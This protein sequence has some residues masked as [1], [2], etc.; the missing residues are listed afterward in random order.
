MIH[1]VLITG[2]SGLLGR[3]LLLEF[4]NKSWE[5]CGLAF[6][7]AKDSLI[8]VDLNNIEKVMKVIEDFKPDIIVHSAAERSPDRVEKEREASQRL[9]VTCSKNL[10]E[11]AAI[12]NIAFIYISTDYVFDGSNPPY[13]ETDE[14]NPLNQYGFLKLEGEK[15]V[16]QSNPDACI[17]RIPVLYGDEEYIGE[18]AISCLIKNL[19]LQ[20]HVKI[21]NFEIR[22][23]SHVDDI[24]AVCHQLAERKLK[25]PTINSI[26]H[27]CGSEPLTKYEMTKIMA[28]VF[29]IPHSHISPDNEPSSGAPRPKNTQLSCERLIA[30]DIG[31]HT[32]FREGILRSF[33]NFFDSI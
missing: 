26:F 22:F 15:A 11:I 10:A 17:L 3:A 12:M 31:K 28:E 24:A 1:K 20:S 27:W 7:R 14:P 4:A 32:P 30:L 8:K 19:Q 5:V 9:N 6:S 16:I 2:A 21:S 13:A 25:D 33:K 23:P 18:S 29:C